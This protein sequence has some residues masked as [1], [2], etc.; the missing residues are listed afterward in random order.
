[1]K[2]NKLLIFI[3]D[4]E[5]IERISSI[6]MEFLLFLINIKSENNSK[7]TN[8]FSILLILMI[9]FTIFKLWKLWIEKI[10]NVFTSS[11]EVKEYMRKWINKPGQTVIVTRDMSWIATGDEIY[12]I[13]LDKAE[14]KELTIV[15]EETRESINNLK[16]SGAKVLEYKKL[17]F[18]PKTRFTFIHYGT[19]N[20]KVAIGYPDGDTHRIKEFE[21]S[22]TI[23][24]SLAEDL[25]KLL[26]NV[27]V[28]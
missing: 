25:L 13:L 5:V 9:C 16:N 24:Y 3:T 17:G 21:K 20:P 26:E 27:S 19:S 1:M 15:L 14:K 8:F 2:N 4:I 11:D 12:N 22:G 18:T 7:W 10:N 28:K 23:E 6:I